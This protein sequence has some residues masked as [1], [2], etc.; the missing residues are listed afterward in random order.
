MLTIEYELCTRQAICKSHLKKSKIISM[1]QM[2]IQLNGVTE[3]FKWLPQDIM[4]YDMDFCAKYCLSCIYVGVLAWS[5]KRIAFD[6]LEWNSSDLDVVLC[7]C[8]LL[9]KLENYANALE[10]CTS[11]GI[12][13]I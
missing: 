10:Y 5:H 13:D 4:H 9:I 3:M 1:K 11:C 2:H 6:T 7:L 8:V 12:S